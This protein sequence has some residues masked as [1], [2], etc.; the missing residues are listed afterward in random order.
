MPK[1]HVTAVTEGEYI[2][3]YVLYPTNDP[4]EAEKEKVQFLVKGICEKTDK[5]VLHV[6]TEY[7]I[8]EEQYFEDLRKIELQ[9]RN[10]CTPNS[11][12]TEERHTH[13]ANKVH[14][15]KTKSGGKKSSVRDHR[16]FLQ[17]K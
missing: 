5:E 17:R 10:E 3:I 9:I 8:T 2:T 15:T 7:D 11:A 1:T 4:P 12:H 13:N 6:K 14:K 16:Q